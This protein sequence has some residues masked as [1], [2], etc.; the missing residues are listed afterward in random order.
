MPTLLASLPIL[1]I[2]IASIGFLGVAWRLWGGAALV[3][4]GGMLA[5][6]MLCLLGGVTLF[7]A[8]QPHR[9]I[10]PLGFLLGLLVL[11]ALWEQPEAAEVR[12]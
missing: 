1:A 4:W 2:L 5:L 11:A 7:A 10:L 12:D 8:S 6:L 9:T 3:R